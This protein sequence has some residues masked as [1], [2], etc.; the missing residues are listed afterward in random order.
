MEAFGFISDVHSNLEALESTLRALRGKPIV[1]LGDIVGY[2][3][4]PNEVIGLLKDARAVGVLGNHDNAVLTGDFA[5]LNSRAAMAAKWTADRLSEGA[6]AFLRS[7]PREIRTE[8]GG[9][10]AYLTHGSPDDNLWEYVEPATHHDL[11]EHY[12]TK[13]AV[14]LIGLGHTHVPYVWSCASGTVFNP[15]SVGQPRD[16]DRRASFAIARFDEGG[17]EVE[18]R[19]IEYDCAAAARKIAEAGLPGSLAER[20]LRGM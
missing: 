1:C 3:A 16:G 13:Q 7:L 19:R 17:V 5:M 12:L 10:K 14:A 4:N 20:L 2:G 18:N 9:V 11:L 6:R 15:G 8:F